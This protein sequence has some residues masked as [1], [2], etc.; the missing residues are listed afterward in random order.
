MLLK[1]LF[2]RVPTVSPIES[3]VFRSEKDC[4]N[5]ISD[6]F[7]HQAHHRLGVAHFDGGIE[8]VAGVLSYLKT[9][10]RDVLRNI[11]SIT[12]YELANHLLLCDSTKRHL[13]F[14]QPPTAS[15]KAVCTGF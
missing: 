6:F 11:K 7:G 10:Q 13:D 3:W 14:L 9:T 8:T 15:E 1:E 12:T 4:L 5:L 2:Q